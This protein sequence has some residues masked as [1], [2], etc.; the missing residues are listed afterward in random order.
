MSLDNLD[1][2]FSFLGWVST[3]PAL[4]LSILGITGGE[5]TLHPE[6]WNVLMPRLKNFNENRNPKIPIEL[7]TNGSIPV[8]KN[9]FIPM[10]NKF[11]S[12]IYVGRDIFHDK[13]KKL[14]ELCLSDYEFFTPILNVRK[15]EYITMDGNNMGSA[16]RWKGRAQNISSTNLSSTH[17]CLSTRECQG[18][19]GRT[20]SSLNVA[21]TPTHITF[22]GELPA[23]S[24]I[25]GKGIIGY[26][27]NLT[28]EEIIQKAFLYNQLYSGVRCLNQ[29]M[30]DFVVLN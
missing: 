25:D 29:C 7:H 8:S 15:N 9:M 26:D 6:F 18:Y 4:T 28:N 12:N 11:F 5:P 23:K 14:N 17:G 1:R 24:P 22:C 3:N 16:I 19:M 13:F 20:Y 27:P 2:V 30:K 10:Y 21:F